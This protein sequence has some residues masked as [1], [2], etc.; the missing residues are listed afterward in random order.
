ML[1]IIK[2]SKFKKKIYSSKEF[3]DHKNFCNV[4][5]EYNFSKIKY[6][7][8]AFVNLVINKI[9]SLNTQKLDY[10]EIGCYDNSC[11]DSIPILNKIG[12]D[13][14]IGGTHRMTSDDFFL[15][16]KNQTFDIIFI[17]GL[18]EYDQVRRD[19][20]N[21]LKCLKNGGFLIIHDM[22]PSN[23]AME[24]VPR[25][26]PVWTGDVWKIGFELAKTEGIN[27][28]VILDDFGI[29]VVQKTSNNVILN[30]QKFFL[31]DLR[32]KDFLNIDN[33]IKY[34]SSEEVIDLLS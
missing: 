7:R 22:L 18:H 11:F 15:L 25:I 32:F 14:V 31:K 3:K 12:V 10:L 20:L 8:I 17:D 23:F 21:S 4:D 1:P 16:N 26:Q 6:N 27:F 34:I 13:P 19:V 9:K 2:N 28:F 33:S 30:D 24:N 5:L 29:G